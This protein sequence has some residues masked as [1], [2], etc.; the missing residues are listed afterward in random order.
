[1]MVDRIPARRLTMMTMKHSW[2]SLKWRLRQASRRL[3]SVIHNLRQV[4]PAATLRKVR[5][6]LRPH[7]PAAASVPD[8]AVRSSGEA[9]STAP[10]RAGYVLVLDASAP[11]PTRD[12]GSVRMCK[13]LQSIRELGWQPVFMPDNGVISADSGAFLDTLG[14]DLIGIAGRPR[15]DQWLRVHGQ[16]LR[17]T[18]LSR[19]HVAAAH[20]GLIRD[21]AV[22]KVI[23]DTVDLH[24]VREQRA[25]E[26]RRDPD[27]QRQAARTRQSE[28]ALINASDT[29]LVVSQTELEM[30]QAQL[31]G[32]DIRLLSNIHDVHGVKRRFEDTADLYFVGGYAHQPNQEALE[33]LV[34]EIHPR[35]RAQRPEIVLHLIGEIPEDVAARYA[36][37]GVIVHGHVPSLQPFLSRCRIALAPL[38]SGAGVKGKVNEAMSH[39]VPVVATPIAAEGM[40][41]IDGQNA[42]IA[43]DTEAFS[44]AILRLYSD[45]ALW[46]HISE[47]GYHNIREHFSSDA[48]R[49]SLEA[50]LRD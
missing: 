47:Q 4:G 46:S 29:T 42:L 9:R 36:G 15:L 17:A 23:F 7:P 11:D 43:A 32:S 10:A 30:L 14:V 41:L 50:L 3:A 1:M 33:W 13:I 21:Y 38:L 26:L 49:R 48:A 31:P 45:E 28:F 34:G 27:L 37:S 18:L 44:N 16:Q 12:S 39:G 25:A 2:Y 35:I 5:A 22:G 40:F 8:Q 6:V 20:I 24:H 19:H